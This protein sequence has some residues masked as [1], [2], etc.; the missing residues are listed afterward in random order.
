MSFQK[1]VGTPR[2]P[3]NS[4]TLPFRRAAGRSGRIEANVGFQVKSRN[5]NAVNANVAESLGSVW[6]YLANGKGPLVSSSYD[7][8]VIL[9]TGIN[10]DVGT[11]PDVQI[12][13]FCGMGDVEVIRNFN[14]P[15]DQIPGLLGADEHDLGRDA[16]GFTLIPTILHPRSRG[17]V[18]VKSSNPFEHPNV[19]PNYLS[20]PKD[21]ETLV[22]AVKHTFKLV[23]EKTSLGKLV[24]YAASPPVLNKHIDNEVN[25]M[26]NDA[27]IE[28]LARS[29][30]A[31][32]YHPT[33]TC[34]IGEVVDAQLRVHGME[35]L[36]V[37]DASVMP[38]LPS[39]NTNAPTIMI[40]EKGAAMIGEKWNLKQTMIT[41]AAPSK[42][43]SPLPLILAAGV[44]LA[45]VCAAWL[46]YSSTSE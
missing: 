21:V 11:F 29:L 43:S 2:I 34:K 32:I 45:A 3:S 38:H 9:K 28:D 7:A 14:Y 15:E 16:Q 41:T 5:I 30:G 12:G 23:A 26:E 18:K 17:S 13:I 1:W 33:S 40:G 27:A 25:L 19:D 24:A 8:H 37:I 35:A 6:S 20:H 44:A 39:A 22:A 4:G 31:T 36:R 46:F 42:K 10:D